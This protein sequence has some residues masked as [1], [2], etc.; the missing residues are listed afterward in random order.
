MTAVAFSLLEAA[1][2]SIV[3]AGWQAAVLGVVVLVTCRLL[4]KTLQP[5]WRFALWLV[6]C[7]RLA[8]PVVPSSP[9]S[10]FQ[11]APHPREASVVQAPE[12]GPMQDREIQPLTDSPVPQMPTL[13]RPPVEAFSQSRN[14]EEQST[15]GEPES[16]LSARAC[17]A[18]AWLAGLLLLA[19]RRSWL[20]F[21]LAQQRRSWQQVVDHRILQLFNACRQELDLVWPVELLLAPGLTG[22]ATGGV[23]RPYIVL[24]ANFVSSFSNEDLR[25]LLL[26]E[27]LHVRRLD[28]LSDRFASLLAIV[29]WFNPIAWLALFCLRRERELA[30]D[31]AVLD[32]VDIDE[33]RR[34]GHLILKSAEQLRLAGS[35]SGAVEMFDPNLSLA[36]R[37]QMIAS[38]SKPTQTRRALGSLLVLLLIAVGLTDARITGRG[39][40]EEKGSNSSQPA[41]ENSITLAG[42]CQDENGSALRDVRVTVYREDFM[43]LKTEQLREAKTNDRGEFRFSNLPALPRPNERREW[44]YVLA[45]TKKSRASAIQR[46]Y[47]MPAERITITMKPAATLQGRVTDPS[48]KPIAGAWVWTNGL[49]TDPLPGVSSSRTD[50]DGRYAITDLPAWDVAKQKPTPSGDGRGMMTVSHC[51]FNVRHPDYG[52]QRPI[53]KRVPDTI[54]IKLHPAAII[55]GRVMDQ[56]TGKPAANVL[57]C[58]QGTNK[59]KEHG[60][61]QTLTDRDG[62][63]RFSSL[64][65]A[66]YNI[67]AQAP[68]RACTAIDSFAVTAGKTHAAP[69]LTLIEGGWIEGRLIEAETGK[70]IRRDPRSQQRLHVAAYGPSHPKSGAACQS[71][72]VD[73]NGAFRL[74]VAPGISYPYIMYPNVWNLTQRREYYQKGIEV[75]SGEVVTLVFRILSKEPIPDPDP[76]PVRFKLPVAAERQA[77]ERIRELGGWYEVDKDNHVIEVNMV[78]HETPEKR[79]YDNT[80]SNTDEALRGVNAFTRLK[81][82]FLKKGQATDEAL[83]SVVG[84]KDLEM[85]LIWDAEKITDAGVKHLAGLTKLQDLHMNGGQIGDQALEVFARLPALQRLGLQGNALSD[86]GLRHLQGMK[87]LRG[88]WIGMSRMPIT[89]A[90]IKH[91]AGLTMLE[92][93]DLQRANLSDEGVAALKNLKNLRHLDISIGRGPGDKQITDA[94]VDTLTALTN[95]QVL[96]LL[97]THITDRG[98]KRLSELPKLKMLW[99]HTSSISEQEREELKKRRPNLKVYFGS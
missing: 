99:L 10:L 78:Y 2:T 52:E 4:G 51:Y 48:G 82:L 32:R 18:L 22:P 65:D 37:I 14:V 26:H 43:Q 9:W 54:D 63:Y 12:N 59:S 40:E 55:E 98:A 41:P 42:I 6:V 67:W 46:F 11:L 90:G 86:E 94:S 1:L 73:D 39:L 69:D 15:A 8:F 76:T 45:Y 87:Q 66:I 3:H 38:H 74:R 31:A 70:P 49:A 61:H 75:K 79:R 97:S 91:L 34:Y 29:H 83:A 20:A 23:W 80:Q 35:L 5:R 96:M 17:L 36:R 44:T 72:E 47:E 24:P 56:I 28:V 7:A 93:L 30:C 71:S 68:E 57:V 16:M 53:Y 58:M 95:L 60:Y 77:A 85:L 25:L 21:R 64:P 19:G 27:L 88:L 50:T 92:Q 84:L 89:D 62:K 81:R 33:A 13:S